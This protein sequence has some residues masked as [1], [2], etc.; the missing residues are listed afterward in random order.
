MGSYFYTQSKENNQGEKEI[1]PKQEE[2]DM[3]DEKELINNFK[4]FNVFWY[5]PNNSNDFDNF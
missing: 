1:E 4:Y 2:E 3:D 5:D